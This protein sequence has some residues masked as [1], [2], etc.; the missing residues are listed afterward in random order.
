MNP[1]GILLCLGMVFLLIHMASGFWP[2]WE[3]D[4]FFWY[5]M[6]VCWVTAF[7]LHFGLKILQLFG[8]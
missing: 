4:N 1:V 2:E 5:A 8:F 3:H 6:L 7:P